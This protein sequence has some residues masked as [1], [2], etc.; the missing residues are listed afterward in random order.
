[1]SLTPCYDLSRGQGA[2]YHPML[3]WHPRN[4]RFVTR[5]AIVTTTRFKVSGQNTHLAQKP[6][7]R[8]GVDVES[9][10]GIYSAC[11]ARSS[12]PID[13]RLLDAYGSPEVWT[14]FSTFCCVYNTVHGVGRRYDV[15]PKKSLPSGVNER[16]AWEYM[17]VSAHR[18]LSMPINVLG[19]GDWQ[20]RCSNRNIAITRQHSIGR[21]SGVTSELSRTHLITRKVCTVSIHSRAKRS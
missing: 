9:S 16:F 8:H 12:L 13:S 17:K 15:R 11:H 14:H 20:F 19:I 10:G 21:I 18:E 3:L 4:E 5:I 2:I 6:E 1:M 7:Y